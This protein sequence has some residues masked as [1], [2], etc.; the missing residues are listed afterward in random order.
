[1]LKQKISALETEQKGA[2]A[3][4][5]EAVKAAV[6]KAQS[7]APAVAASTPVANEELAKKHAEELK[8]LEERLNAAHKAEVDAAVAAAKQAASS[9]ASAAGSEEN[10][11]AVIETAVAAAKAEWAKAQ[12]EA[13]EQ[14]VERGRQEQSIKARLKDSQL[15]KSQNRVKE[16]EAQLLQHQANAKPSA[17]PAAPA[18]QPVAPAAQTK[19]PLRGGPATRG[20]GTTRTLTAA[21][22]G[23]GGAPA[24]AAAAA[25]PPASGVSIMGAAK[26]PRDEGETPESPQAE[27]SLAKR[28]KPAESKPVPIRRPVP[29]P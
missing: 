28:L 8:A 18:A 9:S 7:G 27:N 17:T 16:L 15:M 11:K 2:A 6:T 25:T 3:K 22:G 1:M 23:R 21:L 13:L 20:R 19:P 14:A 4:Q 29:K 10:Q 12:E 24:A 26:R 5:Q